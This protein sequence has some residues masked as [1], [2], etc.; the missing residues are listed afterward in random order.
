MATGDHGGTP[1]HIQLDRTAG[2]PTYEIV[3]MIASLEGKS[4]DELPSF[5]DTVD[6]LVENVFTDP[7]KPE[8]QVRLEFTY[9][10]YRITLNQDGSAMF[11]KVA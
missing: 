11:L 2:D 4:S 7:P 1:T 10:G 3:E 9:A 5:Y 8:A 6:H